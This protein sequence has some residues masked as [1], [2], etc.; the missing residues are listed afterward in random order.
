MSAFMIE[1]VNYDFD[2][3]SIKYVCNH[4]NCFSVFC[5]APVGPY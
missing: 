5:P 3:V 2:L 4:I 1:S